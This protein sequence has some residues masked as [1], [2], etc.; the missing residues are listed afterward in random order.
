MVGLGVDH[1]V[2]TLVDF[3]S[4]EVAARG[5]ALSNRNFPGSALVRENAVASASGLGAKQSECER[6]GPRFQERLA[7]RCA[8][9]K[10][11]NASLLFEIDTPLLPLFVRHPLPSTARSP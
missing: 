6:P 5:R 9:A 1:G 4:S 10:S 2:D 7:A 8:S 11:Y 3:V